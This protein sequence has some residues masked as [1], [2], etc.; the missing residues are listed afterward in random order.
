MHV[1][2]LLPSLNT[3]AVDLIESNVGDV[4]TTLFQEWFVN[5]YP[6]LEVSEHLRHYYNERLIAAGPSVFGLGVVVPDGWGSVAFSDVKL[7]WS[8]SRAYA[9]LDGKVEYF[10]ASTAAEEA[11]W[12]RR[13]TSPPPTAAA[14]VTRTASATADTAADRDRCRLLCC[15]YRGSSAARGSRRRPPTTPR[16]ICPTAT[17]VTTK[18]RRLSRATSSV[19]RAVSHLC[20]SRSRRGCFSLPVRRLIR[21]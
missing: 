20:L 19:E 18:A 2:M 9:R 13:R 17:H 3:S 4:N 16:W 12:R 11:G 6:G 8:A 7:S 14:A 1:Q 5:R 15:R 10:S 21:W